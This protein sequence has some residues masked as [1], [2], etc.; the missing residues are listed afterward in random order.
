MRRANI[1]RKN[2]RNMTL[3]RIEGY[4]FLG[5]H[6][7]G[8][9]LRP[10]PVFVVDVANGRRAEQG[11]WQDHRSNETA[12]DIDRSLRKDGFRSALEPGAAGTIGRGTAFRIDS[13]FPLSQASD[14]G[15]LMGVKK[16]RS[17]GWERDTIEP[18][19]EFIGDCGRIDPA[20]KT[21]GRPMSVCV[22]FHIG[23]PDL[24]TPDRGAVSAGAHHRRVRQDDS[25]IKR[26]ILSIHGDAA[27]RDVDRPRRGIFEAN[28]FA[29]EQGIFEQSHFVRH[30]LRPHGHGHDSQGGA[31]SRGLKRTSGSAASPRPRP[32]GCPAC[33][34]PTCRGCP[35]A[36]SASIRWSA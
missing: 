31:A 9:R 28:F 18:N 29:A 33:P 7:I 14:S 35:G 24:P 4:G 11:S 20:G 36:T 1:V 8:L 26:D 21:T 12:G 13:Y 30:T 32:G 19:Q 27:G 2:F 15:T 16:S 23:R 25:S 34:G 22:S 10:V 6:P 17:S 5:K 3:C